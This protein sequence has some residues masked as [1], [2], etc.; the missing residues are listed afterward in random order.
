MNIT[1]SFFLAAVMSAP[2]FFDLLSIAACGAILIA[3]VNEVFSLTRGTVFHDKYAQ[4]TA[5]MGMWFLVIWLLTLCVSGF[6][7]TSHMT[8]LIQWLINPSSPFFYYFAMIALGMLLA[9]P[10]ALTWK[11]MRTARTAHVVLGLGAC[12]PLMAGIIAYLASLYMLGVSMAGDA[13]AF[14]VEPLP[15]GATSLFWPLAAQYVLMSVSAGAGL[16]LVYLV[17][18]R[19]RDDYGRDY[20]KF[21]LPLAA[22]WAT[23]ALVLHILCQAWLF[24]LLSPESRT[25]VLG[26]GMGWIWGCALM[27]AV[28]CC[29]SWILLVKSAAPMR[30]KWIAFVGAL[31]LWLLHSLNITVGMSLISML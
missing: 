12:L 3:M 15:L 28:L 13:T 7:A 8:W 17:L 30:M 21:A 18:R 10:Y 9:L 16:S 31:L 2:A 6:A 19:N 26:T 27:L 25:L 23:F 22:R 4:Q 29:G 5:M 14:L 1:E 11:K 24:V 20:Y